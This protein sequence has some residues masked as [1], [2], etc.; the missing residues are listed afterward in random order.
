MLREIFSTLVSETENYLIIKGIPAKVT[1]G[2]PDKQLAGNRVFIA[3]LDY[4]IDPIL[5]NR[6]MPDD[7]RIPS[8]NYSHLISFFALP[9]C[10]EY[11]SILQLIEALVEMFELKPFFQ[12]TIN[13]ED[14]ELSIS[15]KSTNTEDF[16]QFWIARQRPAQ[17]VVFFQ[18]R[19]SAL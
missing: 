9:V 14:Y 2:E 3:M 17:P 12:L 1:L 10:E 11:S 13:N 15:M 19:V 16:N 8:P 7:D 18:A 5:R 4:G 6:P